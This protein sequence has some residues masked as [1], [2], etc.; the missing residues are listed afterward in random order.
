MIQGTLFKT[1]NLSA[2]LGVGD[3]LL[4][5]GVDSTLL[6]RRTKVRIK[7]KLMY[8]KILTVIFTVYLSVYIYIYILL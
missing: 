3:S 2:T 5:N 1:P 7:I 8:R 4:M 6:L